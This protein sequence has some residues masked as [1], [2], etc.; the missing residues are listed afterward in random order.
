MINDVF[1]E[2]LGVPV[3]SYSKTDDFPA[4]YTAHSG[5]KVTVPPIL[6]I[7]IVLNSIF[8]VP[9]RVDDPAIAASILCEL[10]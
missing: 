8:K 10:G 4:F 2:T 9:W 3:L 5:F 1:Q 7:T 6:I